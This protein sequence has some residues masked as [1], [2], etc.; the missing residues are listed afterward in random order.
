MS[1]HSVSLLILSILLVL[2]LSSCARLLGYGVLLWYAEEPP[3]PSGTVLPV[4]IRSNIDKVWV[5]GI[6][7]EF[8]PAGSKVNKFEIPLSKLELAGSKKK[9]RERA[10]SF[11]PFALLYAETL[12]DGLPIREHPDN[13]ARRVYRLKQ[14]E[15]I[16]ILSV[17]NGTVAVGA[18]GDPL[19]GEWYRVLTEDGVSGFCFSY[20]LKLFEHIEGTLAAVRYDQ[21]EVEDPI[22]EKL[23]TRIW[24]PESY[25]T[26]FNHRRINLEELSIKYCFDPGLDTGIARIYTNELDRSFSYTRIRSTG[27]QSWRFEGTQLQMN[28]RSETTLA[29]QFT[30]SN[31]ILR[32]LLFVALPSPIDDIILQ[33]SARRE[34]QFRTIYEHGPVY[35]SNNYG[36]L[37]FEEDGTFTWTGNT[38]L[39]PQVIPAAALGSGAIDIKLFLANNL[40]DQYAGAF[41]LRF[42]GIGDEFHADFMYILDPQGLRIEYVP[43]TSLNDVTVVRRASSPL[44]IYFFRSERPESFFDFSTPMIDPF[45]QPWYPEDNFSEPETRY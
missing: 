35:I 9:A 34:E 22:L 21:Q 15:I 26:M 37:N 31:G 5:V 2:L 20:R 12:Q 39:V 29:V 10:A 24:S 40:L 6:P 19:P 17:A 45:S 43:P 13:G 41:T 38:L 4:Y 27:S 23:L 36:T 28:L 44:I 1:R 14:G 7:K 33:E 30:E 3:V 11:A 16:K 25:G 8:Q 42:D 18:S 32:T